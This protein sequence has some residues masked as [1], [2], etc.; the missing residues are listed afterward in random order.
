MCN[1][2]LSTAAKSC[3]HCGHPG[4]FGSGPSTTS[5]NAKERSEALPGALS[6]DSPE[7]D[8]GRLGVPPK[9]SASLGT[10]VE[11][12]RN[13]ILRRGCPVVV[14]LL[15]CAV[16]AGLYVRWSSQAPCREYVYRCER[17]CKDMVL[18]ARRA[19]WDACVRRCSLGFSPCDPDADLDDELTDFIKQ[20]AALHGIDLSQL[21]LEY[22]EP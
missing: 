8:A 7:K 2:D 19:S 4:P 6:S 12:H 13:T 20:E 15:V 14:V 9:V 22:I 11:K 10:S 5:D 1:G 3:P 17:S 21:D 18:Q 16:A